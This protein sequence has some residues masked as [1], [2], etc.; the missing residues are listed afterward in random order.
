MPATDVHFRYLLGAGLKENI[1]LRQIVFVNN[2]SETLKKRVS[3]VFRD[4]HTVSQK[5]VFENSNFR[6]Y[7]AQMGLAHRIGRPVKTDP[8]WRAT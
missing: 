4:E 5:I 7:L 1:S 3:D 2:D 8:S 6:S